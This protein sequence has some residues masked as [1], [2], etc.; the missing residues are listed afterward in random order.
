MEPNT[1]HTPNIREHV[2]DAIASGKVTM[3]SSLHFVFKTVLLIG[4]LTVILILTTAILN[5]ILFSIHVQSHHELLGFGMLGLL[6]FLNHFPWTLFFID[7]AL[8]V[9][10]IY[11]VRSFRF[12]YRFPMVYTAGI[13][14]ILIILCGMFLEQA[15]TP[16]N[17]NI[18]MRVDE[19]RLPQP[20][21]HLMDGA[22][23]KPPYARPLCKCEVLEV[24]GDGVLIARDVRTGRSL[25]FVF[26][27]SDRYAT[28]TGITPG[29]I[30][31]VAGN[32]DGDGDEDD[33]VRVFG[34]KRLSGE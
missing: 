6:A 14:L 30:V 8:V 33:I 10:V 26:A 23:T 5:F 7:V 1:P 19:G 15:S 12:G 32:F 24:R 25:T 28:T 2:K 20:L 16:V 9:L 22:R 29:D 11:L 4:A 21:P 18:M 3:H 27:P 31:F 17:Q 34:L 13:L